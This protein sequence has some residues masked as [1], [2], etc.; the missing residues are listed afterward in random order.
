MIRSTVVA[1]EQVPS[2]EGES[3]CKPNLHTQTPVKVLKTQ[4][5]SPAQNLPVEAVDI[6]LPAN[7][8]SP[9]TCVSTCSVT[10]A[11][12]LLSPLAQPFLLTGAPYLYPAGK[13]KLGRDVVTCED[14][15]M[16]LDYFE[17]LPDP[18][19]VVLPATPD[20]RDVRGLRL[21]LV[22]L[23][24]GQDFTDR[25]LPPATTDVTRN[26]QFPS[27]Y[28]LDLHNRV[29]LGGTYNFAGSRVQLAHSIIRVDKFRSLLKNYDDIGILQLLEFGFS[30]GIA[31]DFDSTS[32]GGVSTRS[33]LEQSILI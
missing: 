21:R 20:I 4:I 28:F 18:A 26:E 14:S 10:S 7:N 31:Q 22:K 32:F 13:D 6:L 2:I 1:G 33:G 24:D 17:T 5:I 12:S 27:D 9:G 16:H 29:R 25:V 19:D 11:T 15:T 8:L 23:P 3:L 30:L